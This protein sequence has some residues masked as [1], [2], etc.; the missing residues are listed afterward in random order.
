MK[1]DPYG[2][3]FINRIA[4]I[5]V[6]EDILVTPQIIQFWTFVLK[7]KGN[8][9]SG[10]RKIQVVR[11]KNIVFRKMRLKFKISVSGNKLQR[12]YRVF[13]ITFLRILISKNRFLGFI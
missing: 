5:F 4:I 11:Y 13:A 9:S 10:S 12:S 1:F 2:C 8:R 7:I 6:V 3:I